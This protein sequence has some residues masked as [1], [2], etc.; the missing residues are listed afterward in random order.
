MLGSNLKLS[1]GEVVCCVYDPA[2]THEGLFVVL[3]HRA[4]CVDFKVIMVVDFFGYFCEV[5]DYSGCRD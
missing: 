1:K 2:N 4:V 5:L 3:N